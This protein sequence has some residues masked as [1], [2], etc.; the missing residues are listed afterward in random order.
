MVAVCGVQL[1][2]EV[3]YGFSKTVA[4]RTVVKKM[5][6]RVPRSSTICRTA[7]TIPQRRF[8]GSRHKNCSGRGRLVL[9][10]FCFL[11]LSHNRNRAYPEFD[12]PRIRI[13]NKLHR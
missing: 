12:E 6:R 11:R 5:H 2:V 9:F 7:K 1:V 4:S 8:R 13:N 3:C 10:A